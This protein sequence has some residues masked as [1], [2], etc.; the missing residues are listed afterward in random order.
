MGLNAEF[1]LWI[2]CTVDDTTRRFARGDFPLVAGAK[3]AALGTSAK[4]ATGVCRSPIFAAGY[5]AAAVLV[6]TPLAASGSIWVRPTE[7]HSS[8]FPRE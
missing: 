3:L 2:I 6:P 4:W 5:A 1:H 7:R 8:S